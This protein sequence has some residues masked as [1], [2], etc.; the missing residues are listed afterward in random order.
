MSVESLWLCSKQG[1]TLVHFS[2]QLK[3][4][5]WNRVCIWGLFRG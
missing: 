5:A 3:R 1:L 4:F 2:A